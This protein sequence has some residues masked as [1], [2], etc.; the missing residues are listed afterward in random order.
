MIELFRTLGAKSATPGLAALQTP[1]GTIDLTVEFSDKIVGHRADESWEIPSGS[2][3][4]VWTNECLRAELLL[5]AVDV[6]LPPGMAVSGCHAAVWRLRARAEI[7]SCRF[8][9][10]WTAHL[11]ASGGPDSGEGLAAQSW[12]DG[13]TTVTLGTADAD[14]LERCGP[15]WKTFPASWSSLLNVDDPSN[16]IIED[17][18]PDGLALDLPELTA[19]E[20]GQIHFVVAWAPTWNEDSATWYAVDLS[21]QRIAAMLGAD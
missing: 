4:L 17:Y 9:A 14:W 8:I 6:D 21:P 11:T 20:G 3:V 18:L 2:R 15:A 1:F 5:G 10:A 7:S 19:G 13:E 16:V 12:D